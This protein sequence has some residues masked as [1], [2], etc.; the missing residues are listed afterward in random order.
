MTAITG[1]PGVTKRPGELGIHSLDAF[2]LEVPSLEDARRFYGAFGLEVREEGEGLGVYAA[3]D[4]HRW[5]SLREGPRKRLGHLSFGLFE[6][7]AEPMKRHIE[8]QGI[9]LTDAPAGVES[10]GLWFR[11]PFGIAIELKVAEKS[12]PNAKP[13]FTTASVPAGVAAAPS[14]SR[15]GL[16][17]PK[18]LAHLLLFSPDVSACLDFYGRAL[19]LRLSDRAGDIVCFLHGIHGSD[20]HIIAFAK[21]DGPGLHHSSWDVGGIDEIGRGAA[22]MAAQGF[23]KGWGLGRHV[24][25]SNYFHY[26]GDPWGSYAEYAA[27][28]DYIP[29]DQDWPAADHPPEDSFFLWG[30][31]LPEGF[32]HNFEADP[33]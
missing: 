32:V 12:S 15:A 1:Q 13:A 24:L 3:G 18:R 27:D 25:G 23:A 19:G 6:E 10:D 16:V 2:T 20:H 7:D 22:Q 9:R 31:E 14:R 17:Q 33:G 30:P 8:A 11:D 29:L 28:I 4:D 26:V 21:S 5:L